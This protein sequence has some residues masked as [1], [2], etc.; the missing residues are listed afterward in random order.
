MALLYTVPFFKR[1]SW[2]TYKFYKKINVRWI[3]IYVN[4]ELRKDMWTKRLMLCH[5]ALFLKFRR[6]CSQEIL[7]FIENKTLLIIKKMK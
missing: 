1:K 6:K 2:G 4:S 7:D 5:I 3:L